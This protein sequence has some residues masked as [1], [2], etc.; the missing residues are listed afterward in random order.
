MCVWER[1]LKDESGRL[2]DFVKGSRGLGERAVT[3]EEKFEIVV[4]H[5]F[6]EVSV[7]DPSESEGGE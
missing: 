5:G 7:S 2:G 6:G 3:M 4:G 1:S